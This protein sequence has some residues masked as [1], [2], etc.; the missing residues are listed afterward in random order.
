MLAQQASLTALDSTPPTPSDHLGGILQTYL[1]YH[2][3]GDPLAA[4]LARITVPALILHGT[5]DT[6]VPFSEALKLHDGLPQA[7]LVPFVGGGHSI[8]VS[9]AEPYRQAIV[10]FL[11]TLGPS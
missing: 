4:C 2:L 7:S 9:H 8:M 10:A 3:H 11:Q 5:A 1:A 6:E